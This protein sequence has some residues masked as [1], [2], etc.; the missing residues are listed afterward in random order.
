MVNTQEQSTVVPNPNPTTSV[1]EKPVSAPVPIKPLPSLYERKYNPYAARFSP[2][3][4]P[5]LSVTKPVGAQTPVDEKNSNAGPDRTKSA[6]KPTNKCAN[7]GTTST[8]LWRRGPKGE[9]ICNACGELVISCPWEFR[10]VEL[11][12]PVPLSRPLLKGEKHLSSFLAQAASGQEGGRRC[13]ARPANRTCIR[14]RAAH[15]R[16]RGQSNHAN[17]CD[18]SSESA[19]DSSLR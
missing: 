6:A 9:V 11:T 16:Q 7:C 1:P 5:L 12:S 3:G 10:Y 14:S 8:P 17:A 15:C 19:S 13:P 18:R 4:S 2:L